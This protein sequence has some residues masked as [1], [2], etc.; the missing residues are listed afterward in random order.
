MYFQTNGAAVEVYDPLKILVFGRQQAIVDSD[1]GR[2]G[3]IAATFPVL[4]EG[5]EGGL[6]VGR[7]D[8]FGALM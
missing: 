1:V 2:G 3:E 7:E 6:L 4:F 5:V 8:P